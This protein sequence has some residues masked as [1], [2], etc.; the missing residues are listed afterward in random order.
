MRLDEPDWWYGRDSKNAILPKILDPIGQLYGWAAER[1][2]KKVEAYNSKLPVICIGNLT[3]GGTGKTPLAL[4]IATH[5]NRRNKK[6]VFLTRGY[7]GNEQGPLSVVSSQHSAQ[8]VGDEPLLLV[9]AAPTVVSRNRVAGAKFI[10]RNFPQATHIIMDDGLQ[11][12]TIKKDLTIAIIDAKRGIGNGRIIP[13]GPLRAPLGF[14]LQ[15]ADAL[16]INGATEPGPKTNVAQKSKAGDPDSDPQQQILH[17]YRREFRGP[18]LT[19]AVAPV[20]DTTWL[21]GSRLIAYAGIANPTRF[22]DLLGGLGAHLIKTVSFPDHHIYTKSDTEQLLKFAKENDANLITTQKDL[23]RLS[24]QSNA[25]RDLRDSS[26][27]LEVAF[28]F[29]DRNLERLNAMI[30]ALT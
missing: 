20:G 21:D 23:V 28:S 15:L 17:H 26:L 2:F 9:K 30:S 16:L 8:D 14:Q 4:F 7:K 18:V 6:P 27:T 10:E 25:Q 11:N 12:P 5:L 19:A 3:A 29:Q 1:R 22:Y 13:A 24:E